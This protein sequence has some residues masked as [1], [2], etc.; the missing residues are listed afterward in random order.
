[1]GKNIYDV[2]R[3]NIKKYR[4]LAGLTQA[5]LSEKVNLSHDYIRQIESL[6]VAKNFSVQ[7]IYD[8]SVALKTDIGK[9]FKE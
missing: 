3:K 6:K 1:M 2:I 7:T 5:E 4:K 8:I 9:F